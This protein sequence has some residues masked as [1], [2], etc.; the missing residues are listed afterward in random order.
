MTHEM[1]SSILGYPAAYGTIAQLDRLAVWSY[2]APTPFQSTVY[3]RGDAVIKYNPPG[4]L[5]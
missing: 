3:F 5:P 1:V 4:N 2:D